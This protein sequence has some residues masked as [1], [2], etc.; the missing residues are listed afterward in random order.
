MLLRG[1]DDLWAAAEPLPF[2]IQHDSAGETHQRE[3]AGEGTLALHANGALT[4]HTVT[5]AV[6]SLAQTE[7]AFAQTYALRPLGAPRTDAMLGAEVV[8]LRLPASGEAVEL[9]S[10]TAPGIAHQRI[11]ASGEGVC[12]ASVAVASLAETETFLRGRGIGCTL[13]N[14][15]LWVAPADTLNIPLSFVQIRS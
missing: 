3:L 11:A 7:E 15:A 14:G 9:A 12:A 6:S 8:T 2:L 1:T 13:V 5:L 4:I 10:P